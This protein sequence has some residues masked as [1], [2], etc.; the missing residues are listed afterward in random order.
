MLMGVERHRIYGARGQSYAVM[1]DLAL[2]TEY[3][4]PFVIENSHI[5]VCLS[6]GGNWVIA[7]SLITLGLYCLESSGLGEEYCAR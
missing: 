4:K 6:V 3:D 1:E 2:V 5:A 7:F